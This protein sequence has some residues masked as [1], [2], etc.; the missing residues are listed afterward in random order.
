LPAGHFANR[1]IAALESEVDR[2]L[3]FPT[4]VG[5]G[6][7]IIDSRIRRSVLDRNCIRHVRC[8]RSARGQELGASSTVRSAEAYVIAR[9]VVVWMVEEIEDI[10]AH[11]HFDALG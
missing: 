2:V 4:S 10:D 7:N 8:R 6:T 9:I 11:L 5:L 3:K 1:I